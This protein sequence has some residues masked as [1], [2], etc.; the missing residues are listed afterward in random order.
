[1]KVWTETIG[2]QQGI[3]GRPVKVYT[4]DEGTT[5][6]SGAAAARQLVSDGVNLVIG[7]ISSNVAPAALP[8]FNRAGI[9]DM[10]NLTF[11]PAA[12]LR[13]SRTPTC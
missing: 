7:P 3:L 13:S 1:M 11:A 12:S 9:V 2:A 10:S 4:V 8:V 6:A 5:P